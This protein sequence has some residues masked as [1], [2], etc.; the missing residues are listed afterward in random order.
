MKP[1][2]QIADK[3]MKMKRSIVTMKNKDD[4]CCPRAIVTMQALA[5]G[6]T[7]DKEYKNMR[8]G[9]SLQKRRAEELHR[10]AGVPSVGSTNSNNSKPFY[11]TFKS[12]C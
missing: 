4:L 11:P 1:G 7:G 8:D 2:Q 9:R 12:K 5:T 6:G 3:L 10:L